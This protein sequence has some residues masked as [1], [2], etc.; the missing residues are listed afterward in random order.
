[1]F[2][3]LK[4]G[5]LTV[6]E[7]VIALERILRAEGVSRRTATHTAVAVDQPIQRHAGVGLDMNKRITRLKIKR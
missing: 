4:D 6:F 3:G 5:K 1:M 2:A 7:W